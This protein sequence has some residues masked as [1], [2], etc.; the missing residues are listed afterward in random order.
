[1]TQERFNDTAVSFPSALCIHDLVA[2]QAARHPR[3]SAVE[4]QGEVLTYLGLMH[5][6]DGSAAWLRAQ[7]VIPDAVVALHL[8]RS[9][10]QVTSIVAVLHAAG[11]YLPL[12]TKWPFERRLFVIEDAMCAVL[13]LQ[14]A[15]LPGSVHGSQRQRWQLTKHVCFDF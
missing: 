7:G 10:E 12:E 11:A 9:L 14:C 3:A 2:A 6:A 5:A 15:F 4:W 13:L 8:E 1:M